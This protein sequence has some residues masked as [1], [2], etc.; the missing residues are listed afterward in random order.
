MFADLILSYIENCTIGFWNNKIYPRCE[1]KINLLYIDSE[2]FFLD[3]NFDGLNTF[4]I[5]VSY[6]RNKIYENQ[7]K[8]KDFILKFIS[9]Y[10]AVGFMCDDYKKTLSELFADGVVFERSLNHTNCIYNSIKLFGDFYIPKKPY[11]V[12]RNGPIFNINPQC[13][14]EK[15]DDFTNVKKLNS[16]DNIDF[17]NISHKNVYSNQLIN[18][19]LWDA[20]KWS[21]MLFASLPPYKEM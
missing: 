8:I 1:I 7:L 16:D 13:T 12:K 14:I 11:L 17:K 6:E 19:P 5:K 2:E 10:I 9:H 15:S 3:Y 21:G 20:A 4:E 18:I